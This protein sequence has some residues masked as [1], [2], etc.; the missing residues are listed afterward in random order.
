MAESSPKRKGVLRL[1]ATA[2]TV[3]T[4]T[5]PARASDDTATLLNEIDR[6]SNQTLLWG[7][8]RPNLYFGVKARTPESLIS[9]LMWSNVDDYKNFQENFRHQCEQSDDMAG[10]GWEEYDVR[11]GGKQV[12]YDKHNKVDISTEFVKVEGGYNGGNWGVRIKGTLR[13]DAKE[14]TKTTVFFYVGNEG[15]GEIKLLNEPDNLGLGGVIE[16]QGSLPVLGDFKLEVTPGPQTNRAPELGHA[17]EWKEQPLDRSAYASVQIP[18]NL[19]WK[20]KELL[21]MKLREKFQSLQAKYANDNHPP[22]WQTFVVKPEFGPGNLH[23]IQKVFEG[24]FEFDVLYSSASA[25]PMTSDVLT[26][27]IAENHETF[28]K[29]FGKVFQRQAPFNTEK[30]SKFAENIFSNLLGGIGFFHGTS[31]VDRSYADEYAEEEEGFWEE[32][33][34]AQKRPGAAKEEGPTELFTSIPSR[35]FFPRGFYWDEGFHLLPISEWDM[36]LTL[37]IVKSWFSL[38]D[39]DGWIAREQILG[40][41]ARSKVPQEFQTQYPHYANPPTLFLIV[42]KFIDTFEKAQSMNESAKSL[43]GLSSD[44]LPMAHV[45][46]PEVALRFLKDI[47]PKLRRHYNWFRS[48]QAGEIR[49][50]DRKAFSSKEAYRWRGRTPEHCLTSGLDDYPRAI[51]PH[52]GEL[53]VDLISW[54]GLMTRCIR[55]IAETI[56]EADDAAEFARIEHAVTQNIDDLH[57][58]EKHNTYCDATIDDFDE[59][60]HV[61][62]KGYISIFPF[63][64]GL[65]EKDSSRL[66]HVLDL[67]ENPEELWTEYGLRSLSKADELFGTGENYWK[68]PIWINLNYLAIQRLHE[69]ATVEGPYQK[70]AARIYKNLRKNVVENVYKNWEETGYAWEQYDSITGKGQR[71]AHFLGWTS[72]VVNLMSMPE[73]VSVAAVPEASPVPTAKFEKPEA[74]ETPEVNTKFNKEKTEEEAIVEDGPKIDTPSADHLDMIIEMHDEL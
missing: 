4:L 18:P 62:H 22:A 6:S 31:I 17:V 48:T 38:V 32:A 10:Y 53:H 8:Y 71:T 63:L 59:S 25:S 5:T 9:G 73:T 24:S 27:K 45:H 30:Y 72:L 49:A 35:P 21:F 58:S 64:V 67:I 46:H 70:Q 37:K 16:L 74:I 12:I 69:L 54:V 23:F 20:A 65:L 15:A 13:E 39:D 47:Y 55:R 1:L 28:I 41:E 2:L 36:D 34:A 60:I 26:A 52:T 61:C 7:P 68:G 42:T 3:F 66:G 51:P 43:C 50:W 19:V 33:Q 14:D 11:T 56:G 29:R 44:D 57:W 40:D